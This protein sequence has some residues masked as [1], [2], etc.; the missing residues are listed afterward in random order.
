M[1]G[2]WVLAPPTQP[3]KFQRGYNQ[4]IS[5]KI[6]AIVVFPFLLGLPHCTWYSSHY[7]RSWFVGQIPMVYS[8]IYKGCEYDE[9]EPAG[10]AY[11][12]CRNSGRI[13]EF[14]KRMLI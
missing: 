5:D 6:G 14:E 10:M 11:L 8:M 3:P 2:G 4:F 13:G 1:G 12:G 7:A 9:L